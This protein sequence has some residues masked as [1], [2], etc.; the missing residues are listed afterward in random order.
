MKVLS[1]RQPWAWLIVNGYKPIEN[2]IWASSYT[3]EL[4]IHASRKHDIFA[5]HQAIMKMINDDDKYERF[6]KAD[7]FYGGIIGKVRMIDCVSYHES[8]W[9]DGDWGFVFKDPETV[10]LIQCKGQLRIFNMDPP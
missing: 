5:R 3:G 2:R 8:T 4:Y 6:L 9:F 10:P 1:V 7:L